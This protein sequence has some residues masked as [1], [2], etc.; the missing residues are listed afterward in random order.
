MDY[1]LLEDEV[2][3]KRMITDKNAY[4]QEDFRQIFLNKYPLLIDYKGNETWKNFYLQTVLY[5][6][7]LREDYNIN[8]IPTPSFTPEQLYNLKDFKDLYNIYVDEIK[9]VNLNVIVDKT[10][11]LI[12]KIKQVDNGCYQ[13]RYEKFKS[14]GSHSVLVFLD[15]REFTLAHCIKKLE[16]AFKDCKIDNNVAKSWTETLV[17]HFDDKVVNEYLYERILSRIEDFE[18]LLKEKILTNKLKRQDLLQRWRLCLEMYLSVLFSPFKKYDENDL[19]ILAMLSGS[20]ALYQDGN[21]MLIRGIKRKSLK[22]K[23]KISTRLIHACQYTLSFG[24]I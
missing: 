11:Q 19:I 24:Y 15:G 10:V 22:N 6:S 18:K 21:V 4:S 20:S 23:Q 14:T 12:N 16:P 8:Y 7:K 9:E 13:Y 1:R 2:V 17:T 5:I 3:V